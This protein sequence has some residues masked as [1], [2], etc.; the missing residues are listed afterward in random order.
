[1]AGGAVGKK[2][3]VVGAGIGGLAAA[4]A[5]RRIGMDVEIY[6]RAPALKPAGFGI[7]VGA[8]AIRALATLGLDLGLARRGQVVEQ[9][10]FMTPTGRP[11]FDLPH[12]RVDREAG[13]PTICLYRGDLQEALW[14]AAGDT[15]LTLGATA[16]G[17]E[18]SDDGV[19]VRFIDGSEAYGDVLVGADGI[20]SVIRGQVAGTGPSAPRY[21]GFLCWLAITEFAHPK[22]PTGFSG[23]YWGAGRRFGIHDVG[24]GRFYWWGSL[25]VPERAA[26]THTVDKAEILRTYAGWADEVTAVV[27]ATPQSAI[28]ATPCQDR[29][30]L[31][32]WGD[33]RVTL[34]GDAAHPMLPSLAQGG[35]SSIEDAVVLAGQLN[36]ADRLGGLTAALR[37]YEDVQRDRTRTM[38]EVSRSMARLEQLEHPAARLLRD[39]AARVM[40]SAVLAGLLRRTLIYPGADQPVAVPELGGHS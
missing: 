8:N 38:V 30:F 13:A 16:L 1:M 20:R 40:P 27:R 29:P 17:Y 15:P 4:V 24:H 5:L 10:K 39:S 28:M 32:Q 37:S 7:S 9:M 21:G 34:L 19:R 35:S 2:A 22:F 3:L 14:E 25:N 23:H 11:L 31:D 6:E 18:T 12:A 26:R 33:G 36:A